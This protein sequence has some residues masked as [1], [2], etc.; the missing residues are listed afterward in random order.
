MWET[1]LHQTMIICARTNRELVE[2]RL[3]PRCYLQ[4]LREFRNKWLNHST[5]KVSELARADSFEFN[6]VIIRTGTGT[7]FNKME[8]ITKETKK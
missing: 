2:I 1:W 6:G 3:S 5:V 4:F 7:D 8:L